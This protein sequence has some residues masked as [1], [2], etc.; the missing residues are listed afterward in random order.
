MCNRMKFFKIKHWLYL[1][2][3]YIEHLLYTSSHVKAEKEASCL[4]KVYLE[5]TNVPEN[6]STDP[7]E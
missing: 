2:N 4:Q 1:R 7:R 5:G 3:I 6:E